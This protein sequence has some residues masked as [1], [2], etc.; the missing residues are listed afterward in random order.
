MNCTLKAIWRSQMTV[1]R[2]YP[3]LRLPSQLYNR[4]QKSSLT[5]FGLARD[6]QLRFEDFDTLGHFLKK[7][8]R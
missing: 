7:V 5:L 8:R 6:P 1:M 4:Y 3:E 2:Q